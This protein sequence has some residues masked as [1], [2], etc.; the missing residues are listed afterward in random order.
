MNKPHNKKLQHTD[1]N[2]TVSFG[3][4]KCCWSGEK[5]LFVKMAYRD[6]L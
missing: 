5:T 2:K 1:K 3:V 4:C 6:M